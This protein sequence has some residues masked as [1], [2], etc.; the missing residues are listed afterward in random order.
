MKLRRDY[1]S[2]LTNEP[3]PVTVTFIERYDLTNQNEKADA[4]RRY[5]VSNPDL[6]DAMGCAGLIASLP[7]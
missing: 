3:D 4:R 5:G 2:W 1:G 6:L 7:I